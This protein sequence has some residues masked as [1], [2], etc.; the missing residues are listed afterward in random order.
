[1]KQQQADPAAYAATYSGPV[2]EAFAAAQQAGTPEAYKAY[3]DATIAEQ[4]RLGVQSPR[5]LPDAAADQIAAGFNS[6]VAGGENAA[7]LIEQQQAQWGSN[8]PLIA[9]QL[10]K[11]LPPEAQVIATGLPKDVAERM[12]SVASLSESEL[13]K[14]LDK[15]VATNVEAAV[16]SSMAPFAQSLQGQVGG[17][18]TFN[19]MYQ[20]ANKAALSYVRQG[21][22]PDKAAQRVVNGMVNDKYE[23]FGTYRVPKSLDTAAVKRGASQALESISADDLMLLPGI[24]GVP[25]DVNLEQLREAVIDGGQ[26][27]PNNDESGLSLTLNGYRLLGKDGKPITRTWDELTEQGLQQRD[28]SASQIGRVRGLGINN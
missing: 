19:T 10:G 15:G 6:Q 3:A 17:I 26:W 16:Q 28:S 20:A 23:F 5:L 11:K 14:G 27:V 7:T 18:E 24:R 13:K 8:F 25:D 22:A 9:Q 4:R 1:M 21:M 2:R 12:A